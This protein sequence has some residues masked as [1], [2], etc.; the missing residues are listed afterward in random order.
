MPDPTRGILAKFGVVLERFP[1]AVFLE[2]MSGEEL[3]QAL[4]SVFRA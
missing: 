1:N 3:A 4:E 2:D